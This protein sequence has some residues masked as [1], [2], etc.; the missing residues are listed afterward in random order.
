MANQLQTEIA[1]GSQ[2]GEIAGVIERLRSDPQL[3]TRIHGRE[4]AF[5]IAM[6]EALVNAVTHGNRY[7]A[8][9]KVYAYY[10]CEPDD[11]LS[12]VIRDEGD[13]FDPN[14]VPIPKDL[15]EDRR[16][17]IHLMTSYMDEVQFRKNGTE[18]YMRMIGH[19]DPEA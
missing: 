16:R 4:A 14:R 12:I 18:V 5:L 1:M 9:R 3:L 13:G 10:T 15:G 8:S 7:D 11:S 19:Q 6:R 2:L 17:G